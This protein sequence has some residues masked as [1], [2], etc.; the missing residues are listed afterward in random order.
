MHE[1]GFI[2]IYIYIF[3]YFWLPWVFIAVQGLSLVAKS[4]G[5]SLVVMQGLLSVVASLVAEHRL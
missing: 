2:F 3:I 4:G 5:Y 1:T